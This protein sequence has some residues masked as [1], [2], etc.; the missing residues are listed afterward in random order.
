MTRLLVWAFLLLTASFSLGTLYRLSAP[1]GSSWQDLE[2]RRPI[3]QLPEWRKETKA[4]RAFFSGIEPYVCDR[5]MWRAPL[6]TLKTY[7]NYAMGQALNPGLLVVGREGWLFFGNAMDQNMDKF[8]G[9]DTLSTEELSARMAY[10][11]QLHQ[12][13]QDNAGIPLFLGVVPGKASVYPEYVPVRFP[14]QGRTLYDQALEQPLPC[15]QFDLR[16]LFHEAKKHTD[17]NLYD[18]NDSHW[19]DF[20]AYLAYREIIR[21]VHSVVPAEPIVIT[22]DQ[23]QTVVD[24]YGELLDF[25]GKGVRPMRPR[26]ELHPGILSA[27]LDKQ[28]SND[29]LTWEKCPPLSNANTVGDP[30]TLVRNPRKKGRLLVIGD[31]FTVHLSKFLNETFGAILYTHY[32]PSPVA[33]SELVTYLRP[34]AVLFIAGERKIDYVRYR[35]VMPAGA[36]VKWTTC[37][38]PEMRDFRSMIRNTNMINA[39]EVDQDQLRATCSGDDG[40]FVFDYPANWT[41][42]AQARISLTVTAQKRETLQLFYT[43]ARENQFSERQAAIVET[44]PGTFQYAFALDEPDLTGIFR[45]DLGYSAG[46]Y[47]L[48]DLEVCLKLKTSQTQPQGAL[49]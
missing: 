30:F 22:D 41:E 42:V 13:L 35:M 2:E 18:Y 47:I 31:S 49:Q 10:F 46:S 4:K 20:G 19:N 38:S 29:L 28:K 36:D 40:F 1:G 14:V 33:V 17:R 39:L 11:T 8:M 16:G 48:Q 45:L 25:L 3:H 37:S 43:T 6:L 23:F 7:I 9:R 24:C 15:V 44:R 26:Q 12:Y 21:H 34:D 5:A 27:D 32:G